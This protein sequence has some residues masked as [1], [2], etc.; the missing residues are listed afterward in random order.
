MT[1]LDVS[2]VEGD[3]PVR[4]VLT[5]ELDI[6]SAVKVDEELARVEAARPALIMLDLRGLEFMDSSGLRTIVSADSRAREEGR[7]LA[8]VRGPAAVQRIFDV[9]RLDE[10]LDIVDDPVQAA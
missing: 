7:R 5:G 4:I 1:I 6:S 2:T 9:T 8:I 3:G 10:R